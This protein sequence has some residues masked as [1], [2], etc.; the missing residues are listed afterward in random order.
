MTTF[1]LV[2]FLF[3]GLFPLFNI[4][5]GSKA[6][7]TNCSAQQLLISRQHFPV[8]YELFIDNEEEKNSN[9]DIDK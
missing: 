4:N 1:I 9:E 2:I 3:D 8:Y 6:I 5:T 7:K